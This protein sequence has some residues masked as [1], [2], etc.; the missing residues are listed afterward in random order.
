MGG[1][2]VCVSVVVCEAG[3]RLEPRTQPRGLCG[4]HQQGAGGAWR[5]RSPPAGRAR[6]GPR[7]FQGRE[8]GRTPPAPTLSIRGARH[9]ARRRRPGCPPSLCDTDMLGMVWPAWKSQTLALTRGRG[10]AQRHALGVGVQ[11]TRAGRRESWAKRA[12]HGRRRAQVALHPAHKPRPGWH[13]PLWASAA[14]RPGLAP[15]RRRGRQIAGARRRLGQAARAAPKFLSRHAR[16]PAVG[17]TG[18]RRH[19]HSRQTTTNG[20]GHGS[21]WG[22]RVWRPLL[23][24]ACTT[25]PTPAPPAAETSASRSFRAARRPSPSRERNQAPHKPKR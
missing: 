12:T 10:R 18:R 3:N 21:G 19:H 11:A 22:T 13:G 1:E 5:R 6:K 23:G 15:W 16:P 2:G 24:R 7:L 14:W 25:P 17:D 9:H 4:R 20:P 8:G